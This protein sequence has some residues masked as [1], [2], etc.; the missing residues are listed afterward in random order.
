MSR[1]RLSSASNTV[2]DREYDENPLHEKGM[3]SQPRRTQTQHER[4]MS[5]DVIEKSCTE[6]NTIVVAEFPKEMLKQ[7]LR[8]RKRS[9]SATTERKRKRKRAQ[10][11][12]SS[13]S[14]KSPEPRE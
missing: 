7:R 2:P 6:H 8:D 13:R 9:R 12:V 3:S 14:G 10:Q 4:R 1:T 11:D 5:H